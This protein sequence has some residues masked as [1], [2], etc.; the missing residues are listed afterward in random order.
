MAHSFWQRLPRPLTALAPMSGVTDTVFRRLVARCGKPD[1]LFTEFISCAGLCSRGRNRLL[2]TAWYDPAEQPLVVQLFGPDPEPFRDCAAWAAECGFA[3]VDINAGCP[4]R[5]VEKQGAGARLMLDLD[6]LAAIVRA[7]REGAGSLPVSVKTRLGY[8]ELNTDAIISRL[9]DCGAAVISLHGRTR[10]EKFGGA[11]HW[12]E[13]ARAA[14]LARDHGGGTLV[15]GNGSIKSLAAGHRIASRYELDGFMIGR[16][17]YGNPWFFSPRMDEP[18]PARRLDIALAHARLHREV[19]GDR[20]N[21]HS[22]KKHLA[23]YVRGMP[24]ASD[25]RARLMNASCVG[26]VEAVIVAHQA[27]SSR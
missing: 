25:L 26:E 4:D 11:V 16:G 17:I 8:D 1:V 5:N 19:Y 9:L 13:V 7:A 3:G 22:I 12:D 6:R 24:G 2:P 15:V 23:W 18:G 10:E 20:Q 14:R 21:F 27:S